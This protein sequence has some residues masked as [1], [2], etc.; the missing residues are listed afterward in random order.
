MKKPT[1][2][3]SAG[4]YA[5]FKTDTSLEQTG[6]TVDYGTFRVKVARAGGKN[7]EYSKVYEELTRDIRQELDS[8]VLPEETSIAI[9][10][11][12]YA[13][14]V[15]KGWEVKSESGKWV[16]GIEA[17]DGSIVVVTV[18]NLVKVFN[19]LPDLFLDIQRVSKTLGV[20]LQHAQKAD[21]KN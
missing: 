17:E 1:I 3:K 14:T 13:R 5:R 15:V 10:H 7:T 11:E 20:Y 12:L 6:V 19:D 9:N 4:M 21:L 8:G 18:D 2:N 16:E